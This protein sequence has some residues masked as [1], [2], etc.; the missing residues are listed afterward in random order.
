MKKYFVRLSNKQ[1]SLMTKE[2]MRLHA[3]YLREL[4]DREVLP[5]CGPC[6]DDTAIM[7][8][9]AP[10]YELAKQ[11]VEDDPFSKVNYYLTRDIIE[12]EE[13]T[14]ENEFLMKDVFKSL[15]E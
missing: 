4:K 15:P 2:L 6:K 10:S 8:I 9:D 14:I 1:K 12:M 3:L 7:I 5:F 13:A 11:Y